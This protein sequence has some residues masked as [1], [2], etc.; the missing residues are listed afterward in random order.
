MVFMVHVPVF[1][2]LTVQMGWDGLSDVVRREFGS[3]S[4]PHVSS[5]QPSC[6]TAPAHCQKLK[7]TAGQMCLCRDAG[8]SQ[9]R[10]KGPE[11][12]SVLCTI[13]HSY[14]CR[15]RPAGP[16]CHKFVTPLCCMWHHVASTGGICAQS[17]SV[18]LT[19][20]FSLLAA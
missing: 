6:A 20:S 5:L 11:D 9:Q 19:V 2:E 7:S 15:V 1:V 10:R 18:P 3:Y 4:G 12:L 14:R 17:I 16:K 13:V 8:I